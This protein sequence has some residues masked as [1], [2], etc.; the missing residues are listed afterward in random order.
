MIYHA[1]LE[2]EMITGVGKFEDLT[3]WFD[4]TQKRILI[5]LNAN[6]SMF[7]EANPYAKE[8]MSIKLIM[9]RYMLQR[10]TVNN[11]ISNKVFL[12]QAVKRGLQ[13]VDKSEADHNI[14][15]DKTHLPETK[16]YYIPK[17]FWRPSNLVSGIAEQEFMYKLRD[18]GDLPVESIFD[19][20]G[21]DVDRVKAAL[22]KEQSTSLDPVWREARKDLAKN[23]KV[24]N[25]FLKGTKIK[26]IIIPIEEAEGVKKEEIGPGRPKIEPELKVKPPE[27]VIPQTVISPREHKQNMG[28]L[29]KPMGGETPPL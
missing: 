15:N 23:K 3:K 4:W 9:H 14:A 16:R 28:E 19:V 6:E 13:V 5:A 26:N 1:F 17:M 10:A 8:A 11:L 20:L 29:P 24:R 22:D 27:A 18:K 2:V 12:P 25:Q 21:L 7:A